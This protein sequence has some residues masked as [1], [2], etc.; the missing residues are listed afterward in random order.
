VDFTDTGF[1]NNGP[2]LR[3]GRVALRAMMR[4][5]MTFRNLRILARPDVV[6]RPQQG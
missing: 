3:N 2:V 4:T 1:D 6:R 5:D